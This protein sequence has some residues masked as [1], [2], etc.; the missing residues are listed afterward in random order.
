MDEMQLIIIF[1]KFV[2]K[3]RID[4]ISINLIFDLYIIWMKYVKCAIQCFNH[5]QYEKK[6]R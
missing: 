1:F 3:V 4:V 2:M 6:I 5:V